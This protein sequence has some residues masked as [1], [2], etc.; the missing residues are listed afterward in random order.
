MARIA[1]GG[2]LARLGSGILNAELSPHLVIGVSSLAARRLHIWNH[3]SPVLAPKPADDALQP[4]DGVADALEDAL[5]A[6]IVQDSPVPN[7]G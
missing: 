2:D 6:G 4:V 7:E 5:H 1:R 3:I